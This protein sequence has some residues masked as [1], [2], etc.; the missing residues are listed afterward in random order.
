MNLSYKQIIK[1]DDMLFDIYVYYMIAD[2][3]FNIELFLMVNL[4]ALG[5]YNTSITC[6]GA[7]PNC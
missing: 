4:R 5:G 1:S 2:T 6:A 3:S 7:L